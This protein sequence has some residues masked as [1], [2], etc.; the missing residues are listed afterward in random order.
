MP[1]CLSSVATP[2][3]SPV[4]WGAR[5]ALLNRGQGWVVRKLQALRCCVQHAGRRCG[6]WQAYAALM[7][8][9]ISRVTRKKASISPTVW[10]CSG[11]T[12]TVPSIPKDSS[13]RFE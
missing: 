12:R 5:L 8:R 4:I 13:I 9:A 10:Q 11:D 1:G 6:R 2:A 3:H 7:A